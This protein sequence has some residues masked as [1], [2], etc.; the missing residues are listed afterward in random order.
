MWRVGRP[1]GGLAELP[2]LVK[3][4]LSVDVFDDALLASQGPLSEAKDAGQDFSKDTR[5]HKRRKRAFPVAKIDSVKSMREI[6]W[7]FL[8]PTARQVLGTLLAARA[9][10]SD[11][12]AGWIRR[13]IPA[14]T[15]MRSDLSTSDGLAQVRCAP[16]KTSGRLSRNETPGGLCPC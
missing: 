3:I 7:K 14:I 4:R 1:D 10:A 11:K 6:D 12:F 2:A 8:R 5:E 16:L 9:P 15:A 13:S